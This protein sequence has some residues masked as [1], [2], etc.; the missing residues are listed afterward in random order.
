M[1]KIKAL[2]CGIS[3]DIML[4]IVNNIVNTL[5]IIFYKIRF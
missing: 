4:R 3:I 5:H 2:R 1:D